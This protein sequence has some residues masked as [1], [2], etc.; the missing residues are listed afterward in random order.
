M[1]VCVCARV[2]VV[3][4]STTTWTLKLPT[5]I[6]YHPI[7]LQFWGLKLIFKLEFSRVQVGYTPRTPQIAA[8]RAPWWPRVTYVVR[9]ARLRKGCAEPRFGWGIVAANVP[10][11]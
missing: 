10:R 2:A 3:V 9:Q 8:L 7:I 6:G 4:G 1:C 5:K 11:F